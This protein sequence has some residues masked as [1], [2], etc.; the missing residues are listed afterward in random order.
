MIR[1]TPWASAVVT[2]TMLAFAF[3]EIAEGLAI[4]GVVQ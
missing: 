2:V 1:L 4:L 3:R